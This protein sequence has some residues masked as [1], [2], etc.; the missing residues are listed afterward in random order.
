MA[1]A[2]VDPNDGAPRLA[3]GCARSEY[4]L[5]EQVPGMTFSK[6][7]SIWRA[8]LSWPAW[9]CLLTVWGSQPL[10]V[11]D[12]LQQWAVAQWDRVQYAYNL[13]GTLDVTNQQVSNA[14]IT[15][16][17]ETGKT[18]FPHQRGGARW[19]FEMERAGLFDPQGN[20]KTPQLIRAMQLAR[21]SG[22]Q[23]PWLVVAPGSALHNWKRELSAW[24]PEL[25]VR[26]IEGT[27]LKRRKAIMDE[28]EVDVYVIAWDNLR[29]HTRLKAY[30]G[31]SL[32]KCDEHGGSTGKTKAQCEMHEKEL[33]EI[34]WAGVIADEAHRM[35]DAKSKWTRA[36]WYLALSARYFWP[37]TGTPI[38]D[39][40]DDLW[41]VLAAIDEDGFP[42]KSRY[43]TLF[44]VPGYA[45]EYGFE[46]LGLRPENEKAFHAI[47]QPLWRRVPKEIARPDM[48]ARLPDVYRNPEMSPAQERAYKQLKKEAL[49]DLDA[50]TI[51]PQNNVVAFARMCQAAAASLD[52]GDGEDKFGFHKQVVKLGVP[53]SKADD[54]LDFLGDNPGPLVVS[55]NSP[56]L[57]GLCEAKLGQH[58]ITS[59]K[60]IGGMTP[61]QKDVAAQMFQE[62]KVRVIFITP[63]AGGEAITL[64]AADTVLFLQPNPSMLLTEQVIGRVDRIGQPNPVRVVYSISPGT[65]EERLH[66]L[67]LEK[68][69]RSDQV[70]RDVDLFRWMVTG[71]AMRPVGSQG[72][73]DTG[74]AQHE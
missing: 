27:A 61:A 49:A 50:T 55:C 10:K 70:T 65:V 32:V 13:R 12:A 33:N 5:C 21:L 53:S 20:G 7:D 42:S 19:L 30:P 6:K 51:V 26:V 28:G 39:A 71:D 18:L 52:T 44:A 74:P 57:I 66:Q 11:N 36:V 38:A 69:D 64:H 37:V 63:G 31:Q 22:A 1:W 68:H 4:H 8:P 73:N 62:G 15:L 48:P 23:G 60:I 9:V 40:V 67:S 54:L 25:T 34:T 24:A 46:V 59:T 2:A 3:V 17:N 58:K 29:Q 56:Q 72:A 45:W 41:P 14:L 16:D 35:Q 47:T 43:L